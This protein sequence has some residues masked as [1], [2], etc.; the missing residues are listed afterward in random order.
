MLFSLKHFAFSTVGVLALLQ[1]TAARSYHPTSDQGLAVREETYENAL[2]KRMLVD[3]EARSNLFDELLDQIV[4]RRA[5]G[6]TS[7]PIRKEPKVPSQT[8]KTP[9]PAT[10]KTPGA[11]SKKKALPNSAKIT[12][13]KDAKE[14]L[15]KMN[16]HGKERKKA[17][18]WHKSKLKDQ[19][20]TDPTL[21]DKAHTAV[22]QHVAHQGGSNPKEPNHITASF[23]DKNRQDI[24]NNHNGGNNHHVYVDKAGMDRHLKAATQRN[25]AE[26]KGTDHAHQ[27]S[28]GKTA[29]DGKSKGKGKGK[30][31][32]GGPS[33]QP[34]DDP[35]LD[36]Q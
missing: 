8:K 11:P 21:K 4:E 17:I 35:R 33:K 1:L 15:N 16:L 29:T 23:R 20:R 30:Q 2:I 31:R 9:K 22:I 6:R 24:P 19:M 28:V 12:L 18:K 34:E 27:V 10:P 36:R 13:G 25:D 3:L 14:E 26:I 5:V 7:G 32:D